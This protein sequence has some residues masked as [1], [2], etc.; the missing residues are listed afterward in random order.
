MHVSVPCSSSLGVTNKIKPI[1]AV[2]AHRIILNER[3]HAKTRTRAFAR[4]QETNDGFLLIVVV[5]GVD[6]SHERIAIRTE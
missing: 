2:H 1:G 6:K 4:V 3:E 5:Y